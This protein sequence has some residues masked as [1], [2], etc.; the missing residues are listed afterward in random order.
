MRT[1]TNLLLTALAL[2]ALLALA[3][4]D[5]FRPIGTL[6]VAKTYV[7]S[8]YKAELVVVTYEQTT[9]STSAPVI[10]Q[11]N[12]FVREDRRAITQGGPRLHRPQL[13]LMPSS[14][15]GFGDEV[16]D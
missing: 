12:G 13:G 5:P 15:A 8:G 3:G 16:R 10:S 14:E 11:N 4:E 7:R 1:T 6:D 2:A 9:S